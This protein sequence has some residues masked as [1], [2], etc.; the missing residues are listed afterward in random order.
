MKQIT[1][2][3]LE[4]LY[5]KRGLSIRA[6]ADVL[7]STQGSVS[8]LM[9]K[10]DIPTRDNTIGFKSMKHPKGKNASG[11]KGGK[12]EIAC[13]CCGKTLFRFPCQTKEVNFCDMKCR[14]QHT[15]AKHLRQRF[16]ML[17]VIE[18]VGYNSHNRA[19]FKCVCDCGGEKTVQSIDLLYGRIKSCGCMSNALGEA[20]P[21][22]KGGP[23]VIPFDTYAHQ[24]SYA[25]EVR[26]DPEDQNLLNAKCVYCGKWFRPS[27]KAAVGR[28]D[29]L[30]GKGGESRFYCSDGCKDACPTYRKH[31]WPAG[32]K[33]STS[34]EVVPELRRIVFERDNWQCQKCG[35]LELLHCHHV[36]SYSRNRML[37]NDPDNCITLCKSCHKNVHKQK[38]CTYFSLKCDNQNVKVAAL[39]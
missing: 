13:D 9:K 7:N 8:W 22:W 21:T 4:N 23:N 25:E 38:D 3:E 17:S 2:Q 26:R 16:G 14:K 19:L 34:R 24:L 33:N 30:G 39:A 6:C 31:K 10:Y 28:V 36:Q 32:F 27:R 1:K 29:A 12:Q 5:I 18:H 20:H 37:A 15:I 35:S 11:W